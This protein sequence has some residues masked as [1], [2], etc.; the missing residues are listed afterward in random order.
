MKLG[1]L[2]TNRTAKVKLPDLY[3]TLQRHLT[4]HNSKW[5]YCPWRAVCADQ[6][7]RILKLLRWP[8][9]GRPKGCC[10]LV[11][12]SAVGQPLV[13]GRRPLHP[14]FYHLEQALGRYVPKLRS[15]AL[16]SGLQVSEFPL[17][18]GRS[19]AKKPCLRGGPTPRRRASLAL[20]LPQ[21]VVLQSRNRPRPG[22]PIYRG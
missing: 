3:A 21:C 10:A 6:R 19:G 8:R 1:D 17:V 9:L 13:A 22:E 7:A 18:R 12:P 20:L 14:G 5:P 16:K 2:L 11:R 15:P 4:G